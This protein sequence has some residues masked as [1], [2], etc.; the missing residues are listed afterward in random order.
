MKTDRPT[1]V[2]IRSDPFRTHRAGE[3]LRVAVGLSGGEPERVHIV[4]MDSAPALLYQDPMEFEDGETVEDYLDVLKGCG[5]EFYVE[6]EFFSG[7]SD[8][9]E[10]EFEVRRVSTKAISQ[11]MSRSKNVLIF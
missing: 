10:T 11:L 5:V 7:R 4:L 6:Q 8:C 9:G 2:I 1:L 3:A